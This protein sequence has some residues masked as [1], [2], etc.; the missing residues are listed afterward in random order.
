MVNVRPP[1]IVFDESTSRRN[2]GF[3]GHGRI[4]RKYLTYVKKGDIEARA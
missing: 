1:E 2:R 4:L 3:Q